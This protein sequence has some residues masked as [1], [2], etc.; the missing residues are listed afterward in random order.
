[1]KPPPACRRSPPRRNQRTAALPRLTLGRGIVASALCLIA[2]L[3][4]SGCASTEGQAESALDY[5]DN[6]RRDYEVALAAFEDKNWELANE[7]LSE[8]KRKYAYS[9]YARLAEL[10]M[11]DANFQQEKFAEAI[12][13]YKEF[14]HDH[15]NDPE[16]PYARYR[17]AKGEFDSVSQSV[18]LPPLEERDLASVNDALSTLRNY[19]SDYPTSEH[20]EEMRYMLDVVLGLLA[21]HEL[22]VARY[23]LDSGRFDAAVA[24][25]EY[26][27][28]SLK[29]SGLEPE[30]LVLLGEIYMKQKRKKDARD[31]LNRLLL[32]YPESAFSVPAKNFL[33]QLAQP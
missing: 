10:R 33:A 24:R 20:T 23:Y 16:V 25:C 11:A 13:S 1:M 7:L 28:K 5:T 29:N 4:V 31:V 21:R 9:R 12:S 8:V 30:G 2:V 3:G 19:L 18:M 26:A 6:A 14:V 15:P 27:L 17:V 32:Q 22:Y